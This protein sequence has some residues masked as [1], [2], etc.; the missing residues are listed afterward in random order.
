MIRCQHTEFE[1][2]VNK[3]RIW[4]FEKKKHVKQ[5]V[6]TMQWQNCILYIVGCSETF[7]ENLTFIENNDITSY[8]NIY[9]IYI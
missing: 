4:L 7:F 6:V 8:L 9:N 3:H 1:V 2:Y 5:S